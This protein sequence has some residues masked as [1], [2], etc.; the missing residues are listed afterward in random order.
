MKLNILIFYI[1]YWPKM[2]IDTFRIYSFTKDL[3]RGCFLK[4]D[5]AHSTHT[6]LALAH[7]AAVREK[8]YAIKFI[9]KKLQFSSSKVSVA[10]FSGCQFEIVG[11]WWWALIG[12]QGGG[13]DLLQLN[14]G[15][16]N[17]F[18]TKAKCFCGLK[19][20]QT[21][22]DISVS[23]SALE[24]PRRCPTLWKLGWFGFRFSHRSRLIVYQ[25]ILK[26]TADQVDH[27]QEPR[28]PV[29]VSVYHYW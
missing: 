3:L 4:N 20:S 15:T 19:T 7:P 13:G 10:I 8:F 12:C 5:E 29:S 23:C 16:L 25:L 11:Q 14:W 9:A 17:I 27:T 18:I 22:V 6:H 2:R 21:T 28:A 1:L 24:S 26:H